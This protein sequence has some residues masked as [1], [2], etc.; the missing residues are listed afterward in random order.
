MKKYKLIMLLVFFFIFFNKNYAEWTW[1]ILNYDETFLWM[2]CNVIE[3]DINSYKASPWNSNFKDLDD[4]IFDE[5]WNVT[6]NNYIDNNWWFSYSKYWISK[7]WES[8]LKLPYSI[9]IYLISSIYK[10]SVVHYSNWK[11]F[12]I[13]W[14]NNASN[15]IWIYKNNELLFDWFN[16]IDWIKIVNNKL[17]FYWEDN[18]WENFIMLDWKKELTKNTYKVQNIN[19]INWNLYVLYFIENSEEYNNWKDYFLYENWILIFTIK[20]KDNFNYWLLD[21]WKLYVSYWN[22]D[23]REWGLNINEK[24]IKES[25]YF[26]PLSVIWTENN[27]FNIYSYQTFEFKHWINVNGIDY[28][29][30]YWKIIYDLSSNNSSFIFAVPN[31]KIYR[32]KNNIKF[33]Q[34]LWFD[35]KVES[36]KYNNTWK[37]F[38]WLQ[39]KNV[40]KKYSC[41][42]KNILSKNQIFKQVILSK[43]NLK[44]NF[45]TSKYIFQIDLIVKKLSNE[46]LKWILNK[47]DKISLELRENSKYKDVL[48]Y[49]EYN[50]S[51]KLF[52]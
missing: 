2:Q 17:I 16:R 29:S 28:K 3:Y 42:D 12:A 34:D 52:N 44:S 31:K 46:K 23:K 51:Y 25:Q 37:I 24:I 48:N 49:L 21:N 22:Y 45:N 14:I 50:I 43:N 36:I 6:F 27:L 32:I 8:V 30:D 38:I 9:N 1:N 4:V 18:S 47:L 20:N 11:D 40:F 10:T 26:I 5:D 13:V 35:Y 33:E 7:N 19:I 39:N 41:I 15:E